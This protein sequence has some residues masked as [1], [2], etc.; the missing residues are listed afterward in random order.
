[1]REYGINPDWFF[2]RSREEFDIIDVSVFRWVGY[3]DKL[4]ELNTFNGF[5]FFSWSSDNID[6]WYLRNYLS[7]TFFV[8]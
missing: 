1:M 6:L 7:I 8:N 2:G 3:G 5:L 4:P